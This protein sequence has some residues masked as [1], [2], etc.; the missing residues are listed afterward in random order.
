MKFLTNKN[1][2]IISP[3]AWGKS[4]LSKHHYAEQLCAL[5][6]RVW[7]LQP[8][9]NS[10]QTDSGIAGLTI[11]NDVRTIRGLRFFPAFLRKP[12]IR[13]QVRKISRDAAAQFDI[14]WSF[15]NSRYYDLSCFG[16][17]FKIHHM[18]DYHTD[19]QTQKAS[20]EADLC[21]GVTHG[22]VNKLRPHNQRSFFIQHGYSPIANAGNSKLPHVKEKFK[23]LYTGNLLIRFIDWNWMQALVAD[24]PD[25]HFFFAG[26]YGRGNLNPH[27]D[28]DAR[29]EVDKIAQSGNVTLL[30]ECSPAEIQNFM[31]EADILFLAYK[32]NEFPESTANAHKLMAYLGSGKPVVASL[33][34]EYQEEGDLIYMASELSDYLHT[35]KKVKN[36]LNAYMRKDLIDRRKFY[37]LNNTY[38]K[39]LERIDELISAG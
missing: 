24:N 35:F 30:G 34:R 28:H 16:Q 3:E 13:R 29:R 20:E 1:I 17:A 12:I 7:F 32:H 14:V 4:M 10:I 36:N 5:G 23:A 2:L 27:D 9:G 6:N 37:A 25:V 15:D 31:E 26:S 33:T 39:Q 11:L 19:F 21:L 8:P 22:I 38:R 18:M